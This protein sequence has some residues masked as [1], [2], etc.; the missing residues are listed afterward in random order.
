M[1]KYEDSIGLYRKQLDE[2]EQYEYPFQGV[3]QW[4]G[5]TEVTQDRKD[6]T[7]RNKDLFRRLIA[8]YTKVND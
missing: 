5:G 3:R 4:F 8:A 6:R 1:R 7:E 2:A